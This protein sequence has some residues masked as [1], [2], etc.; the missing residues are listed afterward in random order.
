MLAACEVHRLGGLK[1]G[2]GPRDAAARRPL[3][4]ARVATGIGALSLLVLVALWM[5]QWWLSPCIT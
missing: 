3:F 1:P 2:K 5:P 4:V